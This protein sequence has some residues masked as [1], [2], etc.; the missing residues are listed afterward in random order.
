MNRIVSFVT[1]FTLLLL[2]MAAPALAQDA[3]PSR[4]VSLVLPFGPGSGTDL[5]GRFL[6]Q[7]LSEILARP[8]LVENKPGANGSVAAAYVA[9]ARPD[10]HTL[11]VGTNST[12]G[13]NPALQKEIGYDPIRSFAPVT[14]IAIFSS[15]IL[16]NPKVPVN[17]MQQ[18]IA[19]GRESELT[20][21]TGNA[22]GVVM[23]ETLARAVG[24]KLLR[25]PYK[26]NPQAM[27]DV[28]AGRVMMMFSDIAASIGQVKAG[29]LRPVAVTSRERS[30]L[31]PDLPTV[32]ESGVRDY[33]LSGW[34]GLFAPS[35]TP[36][37][38]VERLSMETGRIL[39][40]SEV[41][42]RL[43]DI[44]AE[45]LP[46]SP[47]DFGVWVGA[48]VAKWTRLVREAGIQPE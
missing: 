7:L 45:P 43:A 38:I 10:G 39:R 12:H 3:Y 31:L 6:A 5:V 42:T 47:A 41:R 8:V 19:Y 36:A 11:F 30:S 20:L 23:G 9:N 27:Q 48:E 34:I 4:T 13:A 15:I 2:G 14:R 37:A 1:L 46:M 26:S 28:T 24:W 33:D 21:A 40:S 44:G 35:G 17:S 25:V 29:A 32:E 18:L 22:S 16:V